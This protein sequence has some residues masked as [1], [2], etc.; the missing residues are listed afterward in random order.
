MKENFVAI[1]FETSYGHIPCSIGIV[2]FINGEITNE[3][4]SLIKPIDLKFSPINTSINGIKLE[5]VINEREFNFIWNDIEN[6]I[7]NRVIIAHNSSTDI[8]IL[9]KTLNHYNITIPD[10]ESICT[11]NLAKYSPHFFDSEVENFKLSTLA[12]YFNIE[13]KKCHN[14][15]NDAIICGKL[16]LN[17]IDESREINQFKFSKNKKEKIIKRSIVKV[18]NLKAQSDKAINSLKGILIG[19][20][21]DCSVNQAEINEL[22]KWVNDHKFLI[23]HNP[24]HEFM[25]V[26]QKTLIDT[27]PITE[28]IEDLLWLCQKYENDSFYYSAVTSDLQ[29]LQGICHGILADGKVNDKEVIDLN[30]WLNNN[31]HLHSFYPYDEIRSL[32]NSILFDGII[33]EEENLILKAYFNQFVNLHDKE[34]DS[35]LKDEVSNISISA[36]CVKNPKIELKNKSFCITGTLKFGVKEDLLDTI[37]NLGGIPTNSVTLKTDYLVVGDNGNPAWAYSCYGRKVEKALSLRKN[38]ANIMIIH[39][40]DLIKL[41]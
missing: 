19:I 32:I 36:I 28:T 5:D 29:I 37:K 9:K 13:R 4:Y 15:L 27:I 14:A 22:S 38:G 40:D 7:C 8:T 3:Y 24:F 21:L 6:F 16:F 1:D 30:N 10:F 12:T 33:D 26:I 2:E 11:L 41:I 23:N 17:L 18:K 39:E 35:Q 31:E 20:N 34:I 25:S